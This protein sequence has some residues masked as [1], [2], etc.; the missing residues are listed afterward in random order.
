[1]SYATRQAINWTEQGLVPDSVIRGGIRRLLR[2][3][4]AELRADDVAHA[5]ETTAA[6][7]A[8]MNTA[9]IAPLPHKANEQ[10]YELPPEFFGKVL[11]AA[12][13]IQL[14]LL[15][16][17]RAKPRGRGGRRARTSPASARELADG[18]TILELG[19]GWGSLTSVYGR[20]LSA[21]VDRRR[22]QLGGAAPAHPGRG[23]APRPA[24]RRCHHL[25]H[26]HLRRSRGAS[27]AS[28]RSRCS[29]TCATTRA[30]S[31]ASATG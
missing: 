28:S 19:C 15:G 23:A 21:R 6:F 26:E 11:G 12:A 22:V 9:P 14:L 4:L 30:C 1:M 2:E 3:R 5:A 17:R 16:R 7:I 13:Q 31:R 25:R 27:I 10:H 29:S 18:Q 20:M 24:K 8:E